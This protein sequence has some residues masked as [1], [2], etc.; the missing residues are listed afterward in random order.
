MTLTRGFL[1]IVLSGVTFAAGGGL[2]GYALGV[3]APGYYRGV[4]PSGREPGFDPVA[5]G[6]GLGISQGM[7]CGVVVGSI[8][9][10]AV[11]WYNSRRGSLDVRLKR[12]WL[13]ITAFV[14]IVLGQGAAMV[15][16]ALPAADLERDLPRTRLEVESSS[17]AVGGL[18]LA[19]Q[20]VRRD[21]NRLRLGYT[22]RWAGK[23]ECDFRRP[24]TATNFTFWDARGE[25]VGPIV[26][27]KLTISDAF[28]SGR[29]RLLEAEAVVDLPAGVKSVSIM[30]GRD[31]RML[32]GRVPI[33]E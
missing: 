26:S 10:L 6:L 17:Q 30:L 13:P 29:T 31:E 2:L 33:P 27:E 16:L 24:W 7:I 19:A 3:L 20:W 4:F 11:A 23:R 14:A 25:R 12:R 8:V 21:G 9:V 22:L 28:M 15:L 32:T 5:A 18:Q 1:I